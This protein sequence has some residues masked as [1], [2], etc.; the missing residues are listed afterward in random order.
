MTEWT[1]LQWAILSKAVS[2]EIKKLEEMN[3]G[4][5]S[6][7]SLPAFAD[8]RRSVKEMMDVRGWAPETWRDLGRTY[9]DVREILRKMNI[10]RRSEELSINT[11]TPSTKPE[12]D[13]QKEKVARARLEK[14]ANDEA[15]WT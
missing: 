1:S 13:L 12:T 2:G 14:L 10:E 9:W 15:E 4:K 11:E 3:E 6:P 8:L 7:T 5:E